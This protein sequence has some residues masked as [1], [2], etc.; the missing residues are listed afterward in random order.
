MFV[1]L[2]RYFG[3]HSGCGR[4]SWTATGAACSALQSSVR[5]PWLSTLRFG[6]WYHVHSTVRHC[7][8]FPTWF[9]KFTIKSSTVQCM[10]QWRSSSLV[11]EESW[12]AMPEWVVF[13]TLLRSSLRPRS[14]FRNCDRGRS[15]LQS[16][17]SVRVVPWLG[18][19]RFGTWYHAHSTVRHRTDFLACSSWEQFRNCNRGWLLIQIA[20][21]GRQYVG[22]FANVNGVPAGHELAWAGVPCQIIP[23]AR[24][25]PIR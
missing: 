24:S 7:T 16:Q 3:V 12:G 23:H 5:V 14:Q 11:C 21:I 22:A 4:S 1:I 2:S 18:T 8:D 20:R 9:A 13:V 15:A 25:S 17:S 10:V 6:T 19:L